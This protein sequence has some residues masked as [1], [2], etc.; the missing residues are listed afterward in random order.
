MYLRKVHRCFKCL[1]LLVR[2]LTFDI[3]GWLYPGLYLAIGIVIIALMLFLGSRGLEG[4]AKLSTTLAIISIVP[5][6]V[7]LVGAF[8]VGMFDVSSITTNW[9]REGWSWSLQDLVLPFGCFGL[10]Q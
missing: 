3:S 2:I 8:T 1:V 4:G 10:A 6:A 5:I 7:T 9:T